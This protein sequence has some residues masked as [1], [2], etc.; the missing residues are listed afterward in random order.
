MNSF[1]FTGSIYEFELDFLAQ[2]PQNGR[3]VS[4]WKAK[5]V[6]VLREALVKVGSYTNGRGAYRH[7]LVATIYTTTFAGEHP[8]HSVTGSSEGHGAR[9][10]NNNVISGMRD[11]F[12]RMIGN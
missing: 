4:P 2:L 7:D 8:P 1:S 10:Y 11:D 6:I 3:A 5:Y 9:P 12:E